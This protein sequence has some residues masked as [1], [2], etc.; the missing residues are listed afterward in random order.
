LAE[1]K[2]P[3]AEP[4]PG[5]LGLILTMVFIVINAGVSGTGVFL[6]YKGTIGWNPP[7]YTDDDA[8]A[9]LKAEQQEM[10]KLPLIFTM[11]PF[12]ANLNDTPVRG[13]QVEVSV[14]M[15][16]REGYEE[17]IDSDNQA[18]VR[19]QILHILQNKSYDD[20]ATVQGKLF[21]KDQFSQSLNMILSKG[22]VKE[23]FFSQFKIE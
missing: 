5:K 8:S 22:I 20:V 12:E 9:R 10:E 6:A 15:M 21:L 14:E 4:K 1:A 3:N 11:D 23:I 16:N 17:L 2:V 13:I 7:V 18:K 19:D